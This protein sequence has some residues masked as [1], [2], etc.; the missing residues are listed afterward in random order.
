YMGVV[1]DI[2]ERKVASE[3]LVRQSEL[4]EGILDNLPVMVS[5]YDDAGHAKYV[6]REWQ[7]VIGWTLEEARSMVV[8][9]R[10]YPEAAERERVREAAG[11]N[12]SVAEDIKEIQTASD[13]AAGLTRQLLAFSRRQMLKPEV[14]DV[15]EAVQR[16]T[17]T[18]SRL[19]GENIQVAIVPAAA[20]ATVEVD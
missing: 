10:V 4:L 8:F 9:E 16:F 5:I 2:T 15:N 17:K 1:E 14:V 3:K 13:R 11:D 7:R 20:H 19:I 12:K 6:N 18:L